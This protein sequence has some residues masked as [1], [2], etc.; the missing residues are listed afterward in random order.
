MESGDLICTHLL[1]SIHILNRQLVPIQL[2]LK[3]LPGFLQ[4]NRSPTFDIPITAATD[5]TIYRICTGCVW[6][7]GIIE[8]AILGNEFHE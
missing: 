7:K 2:R 3:P 4:V 1:H 8:L 5:G 6:R